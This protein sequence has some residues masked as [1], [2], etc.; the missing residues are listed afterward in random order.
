MLVV[1]RKSSRWFGLIYGIRPEL[2]YGRMDE[3]KRGPPRLPGAQPPYSS[4]KSGVDRKRDSPAAPLARNS[5]FRVQRALF[6]NYLLPVNAPNF[7]VFRNNRKVLLAASNP[8]RSR[9]NF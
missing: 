7:P 4:L 6:C 1:E 9:V 3:G 2:P 5:L 8:L